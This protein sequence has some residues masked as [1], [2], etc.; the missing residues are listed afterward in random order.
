MKSVI[1]INLLQAGNRYI[2]QSQPILV[3]STS[4]PDTLL[5]D[6]VHL[7]GEAS[8]MSR[9]LSCRPIVMDTL[10]IVDDRF[11]LRI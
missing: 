7:L 10:H 8:I 4:F 11:A 1:D 9:V 5:I 2:T 6:R 3:E